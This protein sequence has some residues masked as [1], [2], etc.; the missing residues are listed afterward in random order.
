MRF[1]AAR[2]AVLT[3][4]LASGFAIYRMKT[5]Y[6][7]GP[8]FPTAFFTYSLHP[9]FP[10]DDY[11]LG[12]LGVIQ[13]TYAQSYLYVAY[14]YLSGGKFN[15]GEQKALL[16]LWRER[17][18]FDVPDDQ[19]ASHAVKKSWLRLWIEARRKVPGAGPDPPLDIFRAF[20]NNYQQFVNCTD[21]SFRT[22]VATLEERVARLG[23]DNPNIK[24]WLG[25]QDQVFANCTGRAQGIRPVTEN[26]ALVKFIP[27]GLQSSASPAARDDRDY[28]IAAAYFYA[29]DYDEA[30]KRFQAIAQDAGSPWR[31][32]ARLLVVRCLLRK[33]TLSADADKYDRGPLD[34]A[35]SLLHQILEDRNMADVHA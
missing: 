29:T 8:F 7:C 1:R 16:A 28:Q 33:A 21:E 13:P 19:D 32:I 26:Q 20:G 31:Q 35:A 24:D 14:R 17:L 6:G 2:L 3:L 9:D 27:T 34:R 5:G 10:L 12:K 4:V 11:A 22:A 18:A 25:A 23:A 15:A 30:G